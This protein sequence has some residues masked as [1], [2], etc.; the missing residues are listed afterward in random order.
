MAFLR[1][2][3]AVVATAPAWDAAMAYTVH[4]THVL[5]APRADLA[6]SAARETGFAGLAHD[7][8]P[9]AATALLAT[10]HKP[11]AW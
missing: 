3:T 2:A 7:L 6:G 10:V 5:A 4:E 11:A 8:L 1:P 9:V